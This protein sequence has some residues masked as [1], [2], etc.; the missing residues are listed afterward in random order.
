MKPSEIF[1]QRKDEIKAIAG[2]YGVK[3]IGIIGSVARNEDRENSDFD[4]YVEIDS[5]WE[6][7]GLQNELQE[8]LQRRVDVVSPGMY[9]DKS[10]TENTLKEMLPL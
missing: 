4:F 7:C 1:R 2:R 8:L 3:K 6:L 9:R 10:I 5:F